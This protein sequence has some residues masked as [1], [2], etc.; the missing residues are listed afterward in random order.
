MLVSVYNEDS[1]LRRIFSWFELRP[2]EVLGFLGDPFS[3]D[4]WEPK[5]ISQFPAN[6]QQHE[7]LYWYPTAY[8]SSFQFPGYSNIRWRFYFPDSVLHH[9]RFAGKSI[10]EASCDSFPISWWR[11]WW[12]ERS[13][14]RPLWSFV[15]FGGTSLIDLISTDFTFIPNPLICN[16]SWLHFCCIQTV[17]TGSN[18]KCGSPVGIDCS[19]NIT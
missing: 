15:S 12:N 1:L 3:R 2:S 6:Q 14:F 4:W 7:I 10:R 17:D 16:S 11:D 13:N 5:S 9:S 18:W 8:H 19:T